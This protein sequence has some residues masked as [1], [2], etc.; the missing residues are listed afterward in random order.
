MNIVVNDIENE[1]SRDCVN[2]AFMRLSNSI[3]TWTPSKTCQ[4]Y[5]V[6]NC[7]TTLSPGCV[8]YFNPPP[9]QDIP[10]VAV[11]KC[12]GNSI[13]LGE[14]TTKGELNTDV[15][16]ISQ[17]YDCWHYRDIYSCCVLMTN[18]PSITPFTC[19]PATYK[20]YVM[21]SGAKISKVTGTEICDTTIDF[22]SGDNGIKSVKTT[23]NCETII[24]NFCMGCC[25]SSSC[26]CEGNLC[27]NYYLKGTCRECIWNTHQT[28]GSKTEINCIGC[29]HWFPLGCSLNITCWRTT[30]DTWYGP[31]NVYICGHVE[32]SQSGASLVPDAKIVPSG[33]LDCTDICNPKYKEKFDNWLVGK[34]LNCIWTY[35]GYAYWCCISNAE[36]DIYEQ[37]QCVENDVPINISVIYRR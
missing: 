26:I 35:C 15:E 13:Y 20:N 30:G 22:Y 37:K 18:V 10:I 33:G 12:N 31:N 1:T 32:G 25:Y 14:L 19:Y 23:T 17:T 2:A 21:C 29:F 24:N 34:P 3:E 8:Y 5:A 27:V 6:I 16:L 36:V 9:S 28:T 7:D 11:N 4:N